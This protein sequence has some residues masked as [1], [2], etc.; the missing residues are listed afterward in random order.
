MLNPKRREV[1]IKKCHEGFN[2]AQN[3]IAKLL[4]ELEAKLPDLRILYRKEVGRFRKDRKPPIPRYSKAG[5]EYSKQLF[6]S[7]VL[8]EIANAIA[9]QILGNDG[10]KVRA[11]IQGILPGPIQRSDLEN[12]LKTANKL[13]LEDKTSFALIADIT[14]CIQVGDLLMRLPTGQFG[15]CELKDGVVNKNIEDLLETSPVKQAAFDKFNRLADEF[16]ES[17]VKQFRR[18]LRQ[19]ER[20]TMALEYI[21]TSVGVDI[22]C[23]KPKITDVDPR[24]TVTYHKEINHLLRKAKKKGEEYLIVDECL[25]LGVFNTV[26]LNRSSDVC[27]KDF[28]HQVW[29]TFFEN[30]TECPYGKKSDEQKI[31]KHFEYMLLP[32][33]EMKNKI[34]TPTHRP[35]FITG[36][37]EDFVFDI[38][39]DR[40]AL[41]LYFS[42]QKFVEL[43]KKKE[44]NAAWI[45]GGEYRRIKGEALKNKIVLLDIHDGIIR[46]KDR[47]QDFTQ[48]IGLGMLYKIVYEFER[49]SSVVEAIKEDLLTLPERLKKLDKE[50]GNS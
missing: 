47:V 9:W 40:M 43:C 42:P 13:N 46:I 23:K 48:D 17:F 26:K 49:P 30:W 37:A 41:F 27:K 24:V 34:H 36:I 11:L 12:T 4:P 7:A 28:Q 32:A 38:L 5:I 31:K 20:M 3:E 1:F 45:T 18:V 14:S 33:W 25:M 21:N 22:Q 10:T 2:I 6:Y 8:R 44:I 15:L 19:R 29:H 39:F 16:G 50:P 35:L